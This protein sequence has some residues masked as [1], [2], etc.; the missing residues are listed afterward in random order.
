MFEN[1]MNNITTRIATIDDIHA[2]IALTCQ[3]LA[4]HAE[5]VPD[6]YKP[7]PPTPP[8][9]AAVAPFVE[10]DDA[11]YILAVSGEEIVGL[12][13]LHAAPQHNAPNIQP[14]ESALIANLVVDENWRRRGVASLLLVQ[15]QAWAES[16]DLTSLQA[17]VFPANQMADGFYSSHGFSPVA[18][19]MKL[20]IN[21]RET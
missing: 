5:L 20:K 1:E 16:H 4:A 7:G 10:N 15:A 19:R 8:G 12:V 6:V 14:D 3:S 13:G 17:D 18:K 11:D 9:S 2:I 21:K